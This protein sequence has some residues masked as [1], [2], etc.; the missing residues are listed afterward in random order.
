MAWLSRVAGQS[1]HLSVRRRRQC[2]SVE[3]QDEAVGLQHE[4]ER[5][6]QQHRVLQGLQVHVL[7]WRYVQS[8]LL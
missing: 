3:Q 2:R 4:D 7:G 1:I 8:F 6:R 5:A